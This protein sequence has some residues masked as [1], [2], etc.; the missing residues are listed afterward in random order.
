MIIAAYWRGSTEK[1]VQLYAD[2]GLS[3]MK[4]NNR[5]RQTNRKAI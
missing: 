5:L 3:G 4:I 2:E 1:E